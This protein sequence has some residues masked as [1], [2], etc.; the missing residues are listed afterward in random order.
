M[1]FE[2]RVR[3][4]DP[5]WYA[6]NRAG[7]LGYATDLPCRVPV[8]RV[9]DSDAWKPKESEVW[10]RD[11]APERPSDAWPYD[12]RVFIGD[13]L[14]VEV[15]SFNAAYFTGVRTL[16]AWLNGQTAADLVDDDGE[17]VEW[18]TAPV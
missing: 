6:A 4:A 13:E 3:F 14:T 8:R 7:V 2:F 17:V 10:L 5:S 15:S 18:R 16:M 12:V 9:G 11:P 1:G